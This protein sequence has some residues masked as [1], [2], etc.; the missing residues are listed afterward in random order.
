MTRR[1]S[2]L[3]AGLWALATGLL[4]RIVLGRAPEYLSMVAV[5]AAILLVALLWKPASARWPAAATVLAFAYIAMRL[6]LNELT[7]DRVERELARLKMPAVA[8]MAAPHP[9]DPRQ[10]SVVAQTADAYRFG[11]YSWGAGLTLDPLPLPLPAPA[12]AWEA[13][14]RDPSV[15]GFMTWVRFPWYEIEESPAATRVLIHDARYAVRRRPGGGF[16]GVVV[17]LPK[18]PASEP[19]RAW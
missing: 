4:I 12:P 6:T 10:W 11:R 9:I 5:V 8:V 7:E 1:A 14:R 13:A 17:E 2:L 16:G 19:K 15:R 3:S 18:E